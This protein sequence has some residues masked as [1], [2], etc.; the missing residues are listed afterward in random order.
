MQ[1]VNTNSQEVTSNFKQVFNDAVEVAILNYGADPIQ[2]IHKGV[3]FEI[4]STS[5]VNGTVV[6]SMPFVISCHG[7]VIKSVPIEI[8]FPSG[9]GRAVI[10]TSLIDKC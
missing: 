5:T 8:I 4:P 10:N 1:R 6:P 3:S 2:L 7:L 9:T